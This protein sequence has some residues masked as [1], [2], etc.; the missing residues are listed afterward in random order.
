MDQFVG[1]FK[2]D[3][4]KGDS[5]LFTYAPGGGTTIILKGKEMG[6]IEG[7]DFASALMA[8]WFGDKPA[9]KGLKKSVLKGM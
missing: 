5:Y 8:I 7:A 1:M 6:T 3:A 2:E 9:D 4:V